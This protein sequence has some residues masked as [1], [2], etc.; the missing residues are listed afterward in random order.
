MDAHMTFNGPLQGQSVVAGMRVSGG[1]ANIHFHHAADRTQNAPVRVLPFSRN[2]DVVIRPSIFSQLDELLPASEARSAALW[3]LGGSGK[4]Q[5][6]LEFAYRRAENDVGCSIFWVHADTEAT[7]AQHFALIARKAGLSPLNGEELLKAVCHFIE[8]QP[9]W[10]LVLDNADDLRMFG[11]GVTH[12]DSATQSTPKSLYSYIPKGPLGSI[13]WTSRDQRIASSLV[14]SLRSIQV[15]SMLPQ[16]AQSLLA[17][18]RGI[19]LSDDEIDVAAAL[20]SELHHLPLPVSQAATYIRR[21]ATPVKTYLSRLRDGKKRWD[22]LKKT[23]FDRYRREGVSNSILETWNITIQHLKEEN[24]TAVKILYIL[25]YMD[26]KNISGEIIKAAAKAAAKLPPISGTIAAVGSQMQSF[27]DDETDDDTDGNVDVDDNLDTNDADDTNDAG[28]TGDADDADEVTEDAV[29]RLREFS[30]FHMTVNPYGELMFDMHHL[31][32][33]ATLYNHSVWDLR[34]SMRYPATAIRILT[35]L[36]PDRN[37]ANWGRCSKYLSHVTRA[38]EWAEVA[39]AELVAADLLNQASAYLYD[40]DLWNEKYTVDKKEYLLR[41]KIL[42]KNHRATLCSLA[43]LTS[44]YNPRG[45][46]DEAEKSYIEV[47]ALRQEIF[48]RKD[49]QTIMSMSDLATAYLQQGRYDEAGKI[50]IEVVAL[51]QEIFGRKDLQTIMSMSDLAT[52]YLQQGRYDEA[53]KIFIEVVALRQEILGGSDLEDESY[54]AKLATTYVKQERY[55][56]GEKI[57][58]ELLEMLEPSFVTNPEKMDIALNLADVY[59]IQN[60]RDLS[61]KLLLKVLGFQ[62]TFLG[63]T[64]EQTLRTISHIGTEYYSQR[65]YKEAEPFLKQALVLQQDF[66][67]RNHPGTCFTMYILALCWLSQG[68]DSKALILMTHCYQLQCDVLGPTHPL[69][70]DTERVLNSW[71]LLCLGAKYSSESRTWLTGVMTTL[72]S[73]P[74]VLLLLLLILYV[75]DSY[76]TS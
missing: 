1:T 66:L 6:A 68:W 22:L 29:T 12:G 52:A 41:K 28:D 56:E 13:L 17:T 67:G 54:M 50:F 18:V 8:S 23:N 4:T 25:V 63:L 46:H 37:R 36:F 9:R 10:L 61:E 2:E 47:L 42:G 75:L 45:L 60:K 24:E 70:R 62:I 48:G 15:T 34:D 59:A 11:V 71:D 14:G 76:S 58:L 21:T 20:L 53:E 16:E 55:D 38:S 32:Q 65:R 72:T 39:N 64:H 7:F 35:Q 43:N 27:E 74:L 26:N 51:R 44:T 31:V 57:Y 30:F 69:S 73:E 49:L 3:G 19:A 5:V 33:E 40:A